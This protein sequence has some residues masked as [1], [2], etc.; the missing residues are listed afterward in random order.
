MKVTRVKAIQTHPVPETM[1]QPRG[2]FP[3]ELFRE[4]V[5]V[6]D[7]EPQFN[8]DGMG[9]EPGATA[10]NNYTPPKV[11]RCGTCFARVKENETE[12]HVCEE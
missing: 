8:D 12:Q 5:I 2:P 7:Y 11:L 3:R 9:F 10:Q 1:Q 6:S 4:P